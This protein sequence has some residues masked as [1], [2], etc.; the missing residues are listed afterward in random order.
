MAG[1][2]RLS[3]SRDKPTRLKGI[4]HH[5]FEVLHFLTRHKAFSASQKKQKCNL[6]NAARN[7]SIDDF[8]SY[9]GH[10]QM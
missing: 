6:I 4:P 10:V 2:P 5:E 9:M 8:I 1:G 3:R 7:Q